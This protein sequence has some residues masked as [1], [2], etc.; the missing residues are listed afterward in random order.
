[1]LWIGILLM[2]IRIPLSIF[3]ADPDLDPDPTPSLIHAGKSE[4]FYTFI[5]SCASF[6]YFKAV[7]YIEIFWKKILFSF[8]LGCTVR[9]RVLICQ[10][11]CCGCRSCFSFDP[12]P[13]PAFLSDAD[14]TVHFFPQIWTLQYSKMNH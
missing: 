6:Q 5:H 12:D 9:I 11:Q 7:P 4:I 8:T 2:Q 3:D 14:P 13:D 1:M 10:N